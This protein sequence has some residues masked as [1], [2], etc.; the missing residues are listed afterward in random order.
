MYFNVVGCTSVWG[1]V[2]QCD[3][4]GVYF[5]MVRRG[6]LQCGGEGCTSVW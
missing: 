1:G 3:G 6:V 4:G 5:S 2:L